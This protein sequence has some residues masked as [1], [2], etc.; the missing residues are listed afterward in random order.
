M[1]AAEIMGSLFTRLRLEHRGA[2][3]PRQVAHTAGQEP[4]LAPQQ[5][6]LHSPLHFCKRDCGCKPF[7]TS[8]SPQQL[9]PVPQRH[10]TEHPKI[11]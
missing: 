10:I 8:C 4:P 1:T 9:Q 2:T 6:Q 3:Q 7:P 5:E 11:S